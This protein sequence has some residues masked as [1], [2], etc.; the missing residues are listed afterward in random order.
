MDSDDTPLLLEIRDTPTF[1]LLDR[2]TAYRKGFEDKAL[3]LM[4]K[5]L[6]DRGVDLPEIRE[7]AARCAKECLFDRHGIAKRCSYCSRPAVVE[8]WGWYRWHFGFRGIHLPVGIPLFPCR[9]R[10]CAGHGQVKPA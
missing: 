9:L 8:R 2:V 1:E 10:L 6:I 3:K 4:E 7:L 5:E